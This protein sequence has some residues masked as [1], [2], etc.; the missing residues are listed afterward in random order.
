MLNFNEIKTGK[1]LQV[2]NEP[3][4]IIN[5]SHHKMGR[6]GAVL[7]VKMKN[8]INGNVLEKTYQGNDK[9]EEARTENKKASF[10]YKD[11]DEAYFMESSSFEQVSISLENIGESEKFL[12]EETDVDLLYFN[13]N[14][15]AVKLPIKMDFKVTSSP[16]GV[17]GN[18]SG[19]VNKQVEI[20][21]GA[22]ITAPLFINEGDIIKINTET[23]EY[24]ER[25]N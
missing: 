24:V 14:P 10:L 15:V 22:K 6:S 9:A 12:K 23:G 16:P 8:L 5:S 19:N 25:A 1:V 3:Y 17:R 20:E 7:K 13:D 2:N 4:L 11:Q 21:T 18:S